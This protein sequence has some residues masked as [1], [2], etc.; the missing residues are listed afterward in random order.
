M[1]EIHARQGAGEDYGPRFVA[2]FVQAADDAELPD[3]PDFRD[4][5]RSYM[6]WATNE[7]LAYAPVGSQVQAG[8]PVPRWGWNGRE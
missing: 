3:D 7:V 6:E 4:A 8:L 2:C 5:L 1:L